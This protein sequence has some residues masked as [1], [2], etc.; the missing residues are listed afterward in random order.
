MLRSLLRWTAS[1]TITAIGISAAIAQPQIVSLGSGSPATVTNELSGTYTVGGTGISLSQA[2]IWTLNGA[3]I[4]ANN[5]ANTALGA[6]YVSADGQYAAVLIP[7]TS[8]QLFGNTAAGVDPPFRPDPTL[9][10]STANPTA[11]E[12][13]AARLH[14]PSGTL[15]DLGALPINGGLLVFG[16]GSS[17][18]SSGN[19][20]SPNAISSNGRFILGQCYISTYNTAAGT[21][22]SANTFQWRP[23]IWD[24]D[25]NGGLGAWT[26]L[27]TP[28]RT[29]SNT[30]RRRTGNPY[31][32]S[33]DGMII[34][35]ATEHN[36]STSAGADPDGG[37]LVVWRYNS[38]SGAYEMSYLPNGVNGSGQYYTYSTT[39]RT[40]LMNAAGTI[41]VGMAVDNN[42]QSFLAKWTWDSGTST[43]NN[44]QN[45][46]SNLAQEASWLPG[47]VTSCGLPPIITPFGM[48]DD[49]NTI[50]GSARYSTCGSFMTG[51]FIWTAESGILTDWYD[52]C[53]E[54]V[55]GVFDYYGPTGDN[56]D[57][58]RG[59]P[60]LGSPIAISPDGN[61]IV[62]TVLGPQL[63]AGAAPWIMV[64]S[65]GPGCVSPVITS[66]PSTPVNFSACSSSF[67]MSTWAAGTL[68]IN[69][70]WY[71][72]GQQL[73]DGT[74][75]GGSNVT[76]STN[77]LLR[78][79]RPLTPS[80]AGV[81][82]AEVT[83][84]CG[85]TQVSSDSIVQVD[86]AFPPATNDTCA[87]AMAINE[88][89]NVLTPAQS[90]CSAYFDD[91]SNYPS[92]A[93][94][95]FR[96]DRWFVF[97]PVLTQ[98]YRIETCGSNYDTI[99]AVYDECGGSE[100]ACNNDYT[101]GPSS[102]CSS[103]RSRIASIDL[104]AGE[105]YYIQ[106]SA[107]AAAFLS[108][109][110]TM[111]LSINGA[112]TPAPNDT[113]EN[114]TPAVLGA[115]NFDTTEATNDWTVSCNT[116]I[117]RDVWFSYTPTSSGLLR[118]ATCPGT[119]WNTV[120]SI[121]DNC[122][123]NE[124]ACNDN[125]GVSGCS[126]QSIIANFAAMANQT[127]YIRVAGS[128]TS[129]FGTGVLTLQYNPIGD[130]NC[131]GSINNFDIDPFVQ[132]LTDPDGYAA[133]YPNCNI[134]LAD[135]NGDGV[136]N[137]FDID[138]FVVCLVGNCP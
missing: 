108:S 106:L 101:T 21:N 44:P 10:P 57:M 88:G 135:I 70:Q 79:E 27:P 119:T 1:A 127:Y 125:A 4:T 20:I 58:S 32:V 51:G 94:G 92:C 120:L 85:T 34:V 48:T 82:H 5:I 91:L 8:P 16:S 110:S 109:S 116:A 130:L 115:N 2:A 81:Y 6:G 61:A 73:F 30:W 39:P 33:D 93:N 64:M 128:S 19:F 17:S 62:G 14:I 26:V 11:T 87:T 13:R 63:I 59:L 134:I 117:S 129:T 40:V 113:C 66:N 89:T 100:L 96:A 29:S 131:D 111:N 56:G 69:F 36:V 118:A 86:P 43:W 46:G 133:M 138:P 7:N 3:T 60:R 84:P 98:N 24:A 76:G 137:N 28:F 121:H 37:R 136:V 65:G 45:L 80:D 15:Q 77:Y 103:T 71:K 47:I 122:F 41:I 114:A 132:A 112:P 90:P 23:A 72:D 12:F 52:Y 18:S 123:G 42:G 83:G 31:A 124:L 105:T 95:A 104:T 54:S 97:T 74:T 126:S 99:V 9:T 22:I 78:V 107:P 38:G 25:A 35:G 67:L 75:P 49:G 102:G 50:I 55:P 53:A 68:P